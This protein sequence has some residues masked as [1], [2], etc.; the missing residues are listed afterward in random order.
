[1]IPYKEKPFYLKEEDISWVEGTLQA[2][3]TQEK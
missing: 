1:M 2:M 3:S